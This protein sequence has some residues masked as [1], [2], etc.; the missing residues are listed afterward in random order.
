MA[1]VMDKCVAG[2]IKAPLGCCMVLAAATVVGCSSSGVDSGHKPSALSTIMSM[3]GHDKNGSVKDDLATLKS[4]L[5]EQQALIQSM[6]ESQQ[7]RIDEMRLLQAKLNRQKVAIHITPKSNA[8]AGRGQ[9]ATAS[10]AYVAT[11]EDDSQFSEL[12]SLASKEVSIIPSREVD[13]SVALP[14]EAKFIAIKVNL[15]YTKK[16]SQFLIPV[17]SL[18]FDEPLSLT[19][20]ACDVS[21]DSGFDPELAPDFTTKLKY[22]Q[23]PLVSCQ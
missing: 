10:T 16:R 2:L 14:E 15:R 3:V 7:A 8:N 23:Q 4:Q 9:V 22:Y 19:V 1:R 18:S 6:D 17:S 21:I 11:L 13:L 20:G 5:E 12:Q